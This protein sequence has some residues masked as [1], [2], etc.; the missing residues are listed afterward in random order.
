MPYISSD[1]DLTNYEKEIDAGVEFSFIEGIVFDANW[2][3]EENN[4]SISTTISY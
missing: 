4:Y 1:I 3:F 2:V